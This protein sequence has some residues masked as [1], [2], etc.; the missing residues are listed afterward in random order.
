MFSMTGAFL[1][2]TASARGLPDPMRQV[3]EPVRA[4]LEN[5]TPAGWYPV[6]HIAELNRVIA[7]TLADN[8]E[9]RAR[10]DLASC[11][12]FMANEA[13]NTFMR[14]IMKVLTPGLFAKKLPS[15]WRRDCTHGNLDL[16]T[17]DRTLK[18]KLSGMEGHDHIAAI[19][20][21]YVGFAL[22]R[23]GKVVDNVAVDG[24]SLTKPDGNAAITFTWNA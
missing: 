5:T 4:A 6:G 2:E 18:L 23:M 13:T 12:R 1:R 7:A 9:K 17:G 22:E 24:W 3:S 16:E 20:P 8:D 11:G 19:M 14:L 10:T 15:L 21:G